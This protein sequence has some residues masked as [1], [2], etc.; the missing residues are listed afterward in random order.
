MAPCGWNSVSSGPEWSAGACGSLGSR[1]RTGRGR[2]QAGRSRGR[3]QTPGQLEAQAVRVVPPTCVIVQKTGRAPGSDPES[4][5][6]VW[7][8][9]FL[10]AGLSVPWLCLE[11]QG[12]KQAQ[13]LEVLTQWIEWEVT[14]GQVR[15]RRAVRLGEVWPVTE[16]RAREAGLRR[17]GSAWRA[18]VRLERWLNWV[19]PC[20][21]G[22]PDLWPWA[23]R[24]SPSRP[25]PPFYPQEQTFPACWPLRGLEGGRTFT[26]HRPAV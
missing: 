3:G 4:R 11:L 6:W 2:A 23:D 7:K 9:V 10:V 21:P 19:R 20:Q 18:G 25:A 17:P 5:G 13:R 24:L 16:A 12:R 14:L 8:L 22:W 26:L 15:C 1:W